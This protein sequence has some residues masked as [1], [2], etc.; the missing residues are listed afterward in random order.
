MTQPHGA[1]SLR[2][3]I[4]RAVVSGLCCKPGVIWWALIL[5]IASPATALLTP[6]SQRSWQHT[7]PT[8]SAVH[9]ARGYGRCTVA[10]CRLTSAASVAARTASVMKYTTGHTTLR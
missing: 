10:H 2:W 8:G 5:I 1:H 7:R 4:N 6:Q 3:R 9:L